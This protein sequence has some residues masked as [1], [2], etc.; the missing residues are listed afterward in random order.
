M[1]TGGTKTVPSLVPS[2]SCFTQ[3]KTF[4]WDNQDTLWFRTRPTL[5]AIKTPFGANQDL[6]LGQTRHPS[7]PTRTYLWDKQDTLPC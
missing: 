4:Y 7:V 5:G 2:G 1:T 3:N 6:P